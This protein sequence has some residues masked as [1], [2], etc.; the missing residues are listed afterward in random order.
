M[1]FPVDGLRAGAAAGAGSG[2]GSGLEE[3]GGGDVRIESGIDLRLW[4][5]EMVGS[6]GL[7]L[8][9]PGL[10]SVTCFFRVSFST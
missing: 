8:S 6:I 3:S 1:L 2:L 4:V 10:S 7:M 5:I 9:S